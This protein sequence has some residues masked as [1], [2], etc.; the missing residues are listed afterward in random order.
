MASTR[1][2]LRIEECSATDDNGDSAAL[3]LE[4]ACDA[5]LHPVMPLYNHVEQRLRSR[6]I[7]A[8]N[9]IFNICDEAGRGALS[10]EQLT[11]FHLFTYGEVLSDDDLRTT[12]QVR[13]YYSRLP[14]CLTSLCLLSRGTRS[15]RVHS[16]EPSA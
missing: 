10:K 2:I 14:R 8:F 11:K 3:V 7:R 5:V 6:A 13:R 1:S 4:L 16:T 15:P 12:H 9:R